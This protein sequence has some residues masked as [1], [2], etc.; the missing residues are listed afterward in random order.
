MVADDWEEKRQWKGW[1]TTTSV[2]FGVGEAEEAEGE[3]SDCGRRGLRLQLFEQEVM[4]AGAAAGC[5]LQSRGREEEEGNEVQRE[6]LQ[7]RRATGSCWGY[8]R[9]DWAAISSGD[10]EGR[11]EREISSIGCYLS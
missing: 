9:H 4:A 11:G 10:R 1:G 2:M 6:L 8:H 5:S 7:G 3:G